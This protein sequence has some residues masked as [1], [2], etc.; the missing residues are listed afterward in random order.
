MIDLTTRYAGLTLKSPL[1]V[2][3]SGLT[4]SVD[5]IRKMAAA[6]AGAVVLKSLFEEQILHEIGSM[7]TQSGYPE[8]G[9][10]LRT[11]ARENSV[12]SYLALIRE[13]KAA[14]DIPVIASINC[15]SASEWT[16]FAAK[17]EQAGADALELNIYSFPSTGKRIP[18]ST[19]RVTWTWRAR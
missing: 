8:A 11:Y 14:V 13:A 16:D 5:R 10:Y 1:I 6:G 12:E 15:V 3:S 4:S 9:D 7:E 2:S 18:G 17:I 19:S